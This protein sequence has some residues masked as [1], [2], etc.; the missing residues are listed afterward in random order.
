MILFKDKNECCGCTA[1]FNICPVN[2]IKFEEDNEGFY[3]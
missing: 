2:A 3:K 1:C